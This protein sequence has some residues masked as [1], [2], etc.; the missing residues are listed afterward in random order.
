M[1]EALIRQIKFKSP[2]K[3]LSLGL[4]AFHCK[5]NVNRTLYSNEFWNWRTIFLRAARHP[6]NSQFSSLFFSTISLAITFIGIRICLSRIMRDLRQLHVVHLSI[7]VPIIH[8]KINAQQLP[9]YVFG[10]SFSVRILT[11]P[12]I[13]PKLSAVYILQ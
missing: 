1:Q 12:P 11:K 7:A 8:W 5:E 4:A 10:W 6:F 3:A 13:F 9:F 2:S